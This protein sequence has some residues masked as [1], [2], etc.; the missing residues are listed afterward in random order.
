MLTVYEMKHVNWYSIFYLASSLLPFLLLIYMG[1]R[2]GYPLLSWILILVTGALFFIIGTKLTGF[3]SE[4]WKLLLTEGVFPRTDSKSAIGGLIF[5]ILGVQLSRSWLKVKAFVLDTYVLI[6]PIGLA[7]QKPG[8]L[9]AGCC[10]GSPTSLPWGIQYARGTPAHIHQYMD[11]V[12]PSSESLSLPVHP[13]PLY[14]GISYLLILALLLFWAPRLN[15]PGSRFYLALALLALGRFFTESFRAPEA[16]Y[17]LGAIFG[18]LK[19]LQWILLF[20]SLLSG[21]LFFRMLRK[22]A[23]EDQDDWGQEDLLER[24]FLLI[25]ILSILIWFVHTG[26]SVTEM[27]VINLKLFPALV[28][29]GIQCWI[30]FAVPRFRVTGI[31]ILILP[32][33]LMGQ[34]LP[35]TGDG[36]KYFH[37]FGVGGTFGSLDQVALYNEHEGSCGPTYDRK[38]YDQRYGAATLNYNSTRVRGYERVTFGGSLFGGVTR[39]VEEGSTSEVNHYLIGMHPYFSYD[40]RWIGFGLGA[41]FGLQNYFPTTP[42]DDR[43]IESGIKSFPLLPAASIRVGP[44]DIV[45]LEY[46]FMDEFPTQLPMLTH[47]LSIGSGFGL[48]NGSGVRIGL[49]PPEESYFISARALIKN[50]FM[51][52]CKYMYTRTY[53]TGE[54]HGN[55]V[56]LGLSYRLPAMTRNLEPIPDP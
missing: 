36:W 4:G 24:K 49:A 28:L 51:I 27:V 43:T 20:M 42:F 40:S 52:Q 47:Q 3:G 9:L 17:S 55:F 38:F 19:V 11:H 23:A 56:S 25:T 29:F 12:I 13:V 14:E 26:F 16:T 39:E 7:L 6:V 34:S 31:A 8:C 35:V 54:Q 21:F 46:R 44:Y 18:G 30:R 45:N 50:Q 22:P 41:S 33:L 2:K 53:H 5:A 48:K 32:L 1:R 15:K 37:S 10:F